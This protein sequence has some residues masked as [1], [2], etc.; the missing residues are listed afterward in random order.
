MNVSISEPYCGNLINHSS[1]SADN[2]AYHRSSSEEKIQYIQTIRLN[3]GNIKIEPDEVYQILFHESNFLF[4]FFNNNDILLLD[5]SI[6]CLYLITSGTVLQIFNS[7]F[8]ISL[9]SNSQRHDDK[10]NKVVVKT[11]NIKEAVLK[12]Y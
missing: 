2:T 1:W 3:R 5:F 8:S 6:C 10:R 9:L 11:L 12:F 7:G 4:S